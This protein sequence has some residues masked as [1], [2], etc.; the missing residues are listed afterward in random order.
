MRCNTAYVTR[1]KTTLQ[2]PESEGAKA[3][4]ARRRED[5]SPPG[6][7]PAQRVG[8]V[9]DSRPRRGHAQDHG[10][11][12]ARIMSNHV[13]PGRERRSISAKDIHCLGGGNFG[14]TAPSQICLVFA[15]AVQVHDR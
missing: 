4:G 11:S 2:S 12:P 8:L 3:S 14:R 10:L 7:R 13:A 6:P 9:Y 1:H 5:G 15:L